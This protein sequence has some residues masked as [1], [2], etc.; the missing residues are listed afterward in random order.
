MTL[1]ATDAAHHATLRREVLLRHTPWNGHAPLGQ[2]SF[3]VVAAFV[4]KDPHDIIQNCVAI[5]DTYL[6]ETEWP[7]Q[8]RWTGYPKPAD[9]PPM[10]REV[11]AMRALENSDAR[12]I[13]LLWHARV[14]PGR[15][16]Y[17]LTMEY[18]GY[19]DLYHGPFRYYASRRVHVP[20]PAIWAMLWGL[21]EACTVLEQGHQTTPMPGWQPIVHRDWKMDNFMLSDY[22]DLANE[23]NAT[24]PMYPVP[25][26]VDFGFACQIDPAV[27]SFTDQVSG[28]HGYA[29]PEQMARQRKWPLSTKTN[30]FGIGII[31]F[32]LMSKEQGGAPATLPKW[33]KKNMI[34]FPRSTMV[35]SAE[36]RQVVK[37]CIAKSQATRYSLAQ[38]RTALERY[39]S[40]PDDRTE[41]AFNEDD[42]NEVAGWKQE[43]LRLRGV[44]MND[45]FAIGALFQ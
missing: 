6:N 11:G 12:N 13:P 27:P 36:L 18:C 5:K 14:L 24:F 39:T 10:L 17:R 20:E 15:L 16:L 30:V 43:Y 7:A 42:P 2:G 19:G 38:L 37:K 4:R 9:F 26:L 40:G 25:M 23:P 31:A 1:T 45:R 32:S 29:A 44:P 8:L 41:G 33:R 35:Y 21:M 3:G 28:A 34:Q 22:P